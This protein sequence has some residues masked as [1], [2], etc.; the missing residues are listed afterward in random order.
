MR[1]RIKLSGRSVGAMVAPVLGIL[2]LAVLGTMVARAQGVPTFRAPITT[3]T[4]AEPML[5][6]TAPSAPPLTSPATGPPRT[7]A[8]RFN[9]PT[10]DASALNS[11]AP[12]APA[13]GAASFRTE[14]L[15]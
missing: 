11:P 2:A 13:L 4:T 3:P 1:G 6:S 15:D 14:E 12:G 10:P 8:P 7:I 9:P 5:N